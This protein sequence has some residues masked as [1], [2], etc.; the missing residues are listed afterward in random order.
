MVESRHAGW[1][2]AVDS[3]GK[4]LRQLG[5][6]VD[7]YPR[8]AIKP[9][10]ALPLLALAGDLSLSDAELA[11]A[12]AS[13]HGTPEHLA[14]VRSLLVRGGV[15]ESELRCGAHAPLDEEAAQLLVR[16]GTNPTALHHNCS[17]KHAGLLAVCHHRGWDPAGYLDAEHPVQRAI[18]RTIVRLAELEGALGHAID[19]CSLPAWQVPISALARAYAALPR[20]APELLSAMAANPTLVAGEGH[21]DTVLMR[22]SEGALIAK[23]GAEG[24]HAGIHRP[25]GI[26]WAA[27]IADG[28]RRALPVAVLAFLEDL[29]LLTPAT[30][31][32]VAGLART[33]IHNAAGLS[34]GRMRRAF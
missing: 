25:S 20:E 23:S 4:V 28:N 22:A 21:L 32:A 9:L 27:K 6:E 3:H 12:C 1:M 2:V 29:A 24:V 11:I 26:A 34:V 30:C 16:T 18:E 5:D 33:E 17:G 8:S 13:H 10:Q 31:A 14:A 19:G 7:I 15:P